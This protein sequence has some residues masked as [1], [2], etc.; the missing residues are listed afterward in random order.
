MQLINGLQHDNIFDAVLTNDDGTPVFCDQ[1][2]ELT[3]AW[4]FF[5][6]LE[7]KQIEPKEKEYKNNKNGANRPDTY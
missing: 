6:T 5:D 1:T 7:F 4:Y 3:I 2:V